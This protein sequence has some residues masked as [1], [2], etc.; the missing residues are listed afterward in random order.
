M[1]QVDADGWTHD[2]EVSTTLHYHHFDEETKVP[3]HQVI[4][5]K[6]LD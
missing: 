3:K 4:C 6:S 2:Q 5:P 1:S